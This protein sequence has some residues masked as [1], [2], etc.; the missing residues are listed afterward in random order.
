M[1]TSSF[2]SQ[3]DYTH[4]VEELIQSGGY[5]GIQQ[6]TTASNVATSRSRDLM[7]SEAPKSESL[8]SEDFGG[9]AYSEVQVDELKPNNHPWHGWAEKEFSGIANYGG[10]V[11]NALLSG[12]YGEFRKVSVDTDLNSETLN[13]SWSSSFGQNIYVKQNAGIGGG[14]Y[15]GPNV[16]Q[17]LPV[18]EYGIK[19]DS[20]NT[21][22]LYVA[23]TGYVYDLTTEV[24]STDNLTA[25]TAKIGKLNVTT[26]SKVTGSF[27]VKGNSA[28]TGSVN[29][30]GDEYISGSE[31][32]TGIATFHTTSVFQKDVYVGGNLFVEGSASYINTDQLYVEDKSITVASGAVSPEQ[33]DGAGFDIAGADV[34]FH[35]NAENDQMDLNKGL[36]VSGGLVVTG[37]SNISGNLVVSNNIT[38]SNLRLSGDI[39]ATTGQI[40]KLTASS[41]TASQVK[42]TNITA[43]FFTGSFIGDGSKLTN[44]TMSVS[45]SPK[46]KHVINLTAGEEFSVTHPFK[47]QNVIVQV[48]KWRDLGPGEWPTED[49][50]ANWNEPAIQVSDATVTV[51]PND[52]PDDTDKYKVT[53]QY[54]TELHG[55]VVIA[56]AGLYLPAYLSGSSG[57]VYVGGSGYVDIVEA[58]REVRWFG[59]DLD[60]ETGESL[61]I[62]PENAVP[63]N[64]EEIE[65]GESYK[66]Q[67][68]LGT[69][70]VIVQVYKYYP[71]SN[72]EWT[73]VQI[74]PEYIAVNDINEVEIKFS[75]DPEPGEDPILPQYFGYVVLGKAGCILKNT[76]IDSSAASLDEAGVHYGTSGSYSFND[77]S[78]E[79]LIVE[80]K[81]SAK[82]AD[83]AENL[84]VGTYIDTPRIGN[85]NTGDQYYHD[86]YDSESLWGSYM[87][88]TDRGIASY[89]RNYGE[90][91]EDTPDDY[92]WERVKEVPTA[93]LLD[94]N[95]DLYLRGDLHTNTTFNTSD[96][97]E[98]HNIE[99]LENALENVMRLRG[100]SFE[101]NKDGQRSI[102]T[103][104][105][106]VQ[107][108]YPELT[109]VYKNLDGYERLA[110]NYE[111][112][113]GV[114]IEAVKALAIRVEQLEKNE[115]R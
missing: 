17:K 50:T 58:T 62:I 23:N 75:A 48:Y 57:S 107:S 71:R 16:Y 110:V 6:I 52:D 2:Q 59:N 19:D 8:R 40:T 31:T 80:D 64:R 94:S 82:S 43:S 55:Y 29:V 49:E 103:I 41:V 86:Y 84:K 102:G 28:F 45:D 39:A 15:I 100:V 106:E 7:N 9:Y 72:E 27:Q 38:A 112:L 37:S 60:P 78:T 47:T 91:D 68:N 88:F 85:L 35:Y 109:K 70:N 90:T 98:K 46:C 53:I 63:W 42:A 101:W 105:Q 11:R 66:F 81:I 104:A 115:N 1:I 5:P 26:S 77:V 22:D 20:G 74:Y 33:A 3:S 114:L 93:S 96:A 95:G 54:P 12:S 32:V 108:I 113:V 76:L 24:F 99:T 4:S 111:G 51:F 34:T 67:H 89:V 25:N 21:Y 30:K 18:D 36:N 65:K 73:P 79:Q 87:E 10:L 56:D 61:K 69:K 97:R 92:S 83:I 14:L 13:V 44:V